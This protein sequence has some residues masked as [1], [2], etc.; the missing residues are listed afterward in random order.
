M[1]Y[2]KNILEFSKKLLDLK[3]VDF[4]YFYRN[5]ETLKTQNV[6]S[7][8]DKNVRAGYSVRQNSRTGTQSAFYRIVEEEKKRIAEKDGE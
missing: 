4:S 6:G 5:I 7:L 3:G 1:E 2:G 8:I